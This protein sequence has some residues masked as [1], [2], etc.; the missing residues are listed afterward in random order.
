MAQQVAQ[1]G[2]LEPFGNGVSGLHNADSRS[3]APANLDG[4]CEA[5]TA[6]ASPVSS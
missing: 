1:Q 3:A 6:L 5:V 2:R 4:R